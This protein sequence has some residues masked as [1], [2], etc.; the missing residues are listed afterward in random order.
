MT[1]PLVGADVRD[2]GDA[3]RYWERPADF[4]LTIEN[5]RIGLDVFAPVSR[6][7]HSGDM[8]FYAPLMAAIGAGA[9]D[10]RDRVM[11]DYVVDPEGTCG[12]CEPSAAA[13]EA[14][15]SQLARVST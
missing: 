14:E 15:L 2:F 11:W 13:E 9:A 10:A 7:S 5:H 3:S 1:K 8:D 4:G 6:V 12:K